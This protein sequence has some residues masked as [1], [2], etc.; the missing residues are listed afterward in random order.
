[1]AEKVAS[2]FAGLDKALLRS[3]KQT[4]SPTLPENDQHGNNTA[5]DD[6]EARK[7]Q[8]QTTLKQANYRVANDI[9]PGK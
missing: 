2:P 7:Q 4:P 6:I 8:Q 9:K 3:T 1:M 5:A